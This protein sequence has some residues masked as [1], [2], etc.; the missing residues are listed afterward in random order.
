MQ[1]SFPLNAAMLTV[2]M[3]RYDVKRWATA[4]ENKTRKSLLQFDYGFRSA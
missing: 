3:Y 1:T 2:W 4:I